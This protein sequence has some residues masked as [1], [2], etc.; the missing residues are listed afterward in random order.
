MIPPRAS[1]LPNRSLRLAGRCIGGTL[2]LFPIQELFAMANSFDI[3][4]RDHWSF[5]L[6]LLGA[7]LQLEGCRQ[8]ATPG[9]ESLH[10]STW[11]DPQDKIGRAHV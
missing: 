1:R 9:Q 7:R 11:L 5:R 2:R 4:S 6:V 3:Q 8:S 10:C